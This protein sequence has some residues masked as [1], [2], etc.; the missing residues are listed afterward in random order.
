MQLNVAD[1]HKLQ[2][3]CRLSVTGGFRAP[4]SL[5]FR[6]SCLNPLYPLDWSREIRFL[7]LHKIKRG[8]VIQVRK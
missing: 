7:G 8:L 3:G 1:A 6:R 2:L 4:L 5:F